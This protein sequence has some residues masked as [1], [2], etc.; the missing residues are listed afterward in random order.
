MVG[1]QDTSRMEN[2]L[3]AIE[4]NIIMLQQYYFICMIILGYNCVVA[5][6]YI[7]SVLV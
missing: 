1:A 3:S 7:I 4:K 5:T 2:I 6:G